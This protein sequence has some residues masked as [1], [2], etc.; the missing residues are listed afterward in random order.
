[1]PGFL[2]RVSREGLSGWYVANQHGA[3]RRLRHLSRAVLVTVN[4]RDRF[5]ALCQEARPD[6]VDAGITSDPRVGFDAPLTLAVGDLVQVRALDSGRLLNHGVAIV[7]IDS[8]VAT[9]R[10]RFL[11]TETYGDLPAFRPMLASLP[12][13]LA[14]HSF[15]P[16]FGQDGHLAALAVRTANGTMVIHGERPAGDA[17]WLAKL[18]RDFLAPNGIRAPLV[19]AMLPA[20]S[21][22]AHAG[23]ANLLFEFIDGKPLSGFGADMESEALHRGVIADV[24]SFHRLPWPAGMKRDRR[25]RRAVNKMIRTAGWMALKRGRYRELTMLARMLVA[26]WRLPRVFSHGDLHANNVLVDGKGRPV[27]IDWDHAGVRPIGFDL[28]RLLLGVPPQEAEAWVGHGPECRLGYVIFTYLALS[29]RMDDCYGSAEGRFLLER[30]DALT[31]NR[32]KHPPT[33]VT[34]S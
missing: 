20:E 10:D 1:M 18:H 5:C 17:A 15:R 26:I 30:F 33:S 4:G 6:V 12:S 34:A 2:D 22:A 19:K 14:I 32:G 13:P 25:G 23:K 9:V 7:E 31:K 21:S 8:V 24:L 29:L 16:L 27:F 11:D 3:L 28:S